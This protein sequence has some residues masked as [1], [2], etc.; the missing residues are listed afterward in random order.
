M[1]TDAKILTS[2]APETKSKRVRGRVRGVSGCYLHFACS[3]LSEE[4]RKCSVRMKHPQ[5]LWL[6][7]DLIH[8]FKDA[9]VSLYVGLSLCWVFFYSSYLATPVCVLSAAFL[10]PPSTVP[11]SLFVWFSVRFRFCGFKRSNSRFQ[12]PDE[13]EAEE[14]RIILQTVPASFTPHIKLNVAALYSDCSLTGLE[15]YQRSHQQVGALRGCFSAAE[16]HIQLFS[17]P[18]CRQITASVP[19]HSRCHEYAFI[20]C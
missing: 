16:R 18:I 5:H 9:S 17:F 12:I 11:S 6:R 19:S 8:G 4:H 14:E 13:S 2:V 3:T 15:C 7:R 1:E 20:T 10:T